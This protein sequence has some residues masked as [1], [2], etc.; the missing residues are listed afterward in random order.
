MPHVMCYVTGYYATALIKP[1]PAGVLGRLV[2]TKRCQEKYCGLGSANIDTTSNFHFN[3]I[4]TSTSYSTRLNGT[5]IYPS[6]VVIGEAL[7]VWLEVNEWRSC[8]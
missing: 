4:S 2:T 1:K 7:I 5:L 3:F 6:F 8:L